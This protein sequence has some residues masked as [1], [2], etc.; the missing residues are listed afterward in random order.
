MPRAS[1]TRSAYRCRRVSSARF[2]NRSPIRSAPASALERLGLPARVSDYAPPLLDE[3]TASG[4]VVWA[5]AGAL[6]GDDGWVTVSLAD[7]AP[8]LLAPPDQTLTLTPLHRSIRDALAA[9]G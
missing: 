4:E 8:L 9:G 5:G 2:S 7:A 3:L 6:P 1:G